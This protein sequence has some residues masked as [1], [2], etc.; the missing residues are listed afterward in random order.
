MNEVIL[1][2]G[3]VR[4]QINLDP[5]IWIVDERKIPMEEY[6]PGVEGYGMKLSIF[7]EH[8]EPDPDATHVICHQSDGN[9]I[10]I[11]L[12]EARSGILRFTRDG[13]PIR[14]DGP[15]LLYL[16]KGSLAGQPI[17]YLTKLEVV[18]EK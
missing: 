9:Q 7:L 13:K 3:A 5:T 14:P 10:K 6:F 12:E 15:A 4:F 8:A 11:T 16:Q 1:I 17:G 2:T 18:K